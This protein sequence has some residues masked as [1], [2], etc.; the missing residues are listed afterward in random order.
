MRGFLSLTVVVFVFLFRYFCVLAFPPQS[1]PGEHQS[2]SHLTLNI[3]GIYLSTHK[4]LL[5]HN[6][7]NST[8]RTPSEALNEFF[9]KDRDSQ[10]HFLENVYAITNYQ[11]EVQR[12]LADKAYYHVNGEQI[13][14]AHNHVRSLR[15]SLID[16]SKSASTADIEILRERTG[17]CLYTIQQFYSNTNWVELNDDTI[18]KEFGIK[19][20]LPEAVN[21]LSEDTCYDCPTDLESIQ[22]GMCMNNTITT[23]LTSGY[24]AGQDVAKPLKT[25][26]KTGK[27]SHG[28]QDD[29]TRL[30]TATG[31]IYKGRSS[32]AHAPHYHLHEQAFEAAKQASVYFLS[33]EDDGLFNKLGIHLS[34]EIFQIKSNTGNKE[35]KDYSIAFI[36]DVTGSMSDNI[37]GVKQGTTSFVNAIKASENV[38]EKYIL[39]TFS[40]PVDFETSRVTADADE[41]ID[42]LGSL[43]ASG[44]ADCPEY[45][46][47]GL[48]TGATLSN[49]NSPV[50]IYTDAPAKDPEK[51]AEAIRILLEKNIT[52]KFRL[53]NE[54]GR[55]RKR[56]I[57]RYKRQSSV[58]DRIAQTTGGD[59]QRFSSS[60]ELASKVEEDLLNDLNII[61]SNSSQTLDT[62]NLPSSTSVIK[63][64]T[65]D[66]D[67]TNNLTIEVDD[68][69]DSLHIEINGT[70]NS[71]DIQLRNPNGTLILLESVNG[72]V[73]QT[74]IQISIQT[75]EKGEWTLKKVNNNNQ[76]N[77]TITA[78]S[79]FDITSTLLEMSTEGIPYPVKGNP[80]S[81][82]EYL[83]VTSLQNLPTNYTVSFLTLVD[84]TGQTISKMNASLL[85]ASPSLQYY[86]K[87]TITKQISGIQ[88]HGADFTGRPFL[89]S[90]RHAITPVDVSLR[91]RPFVGDLSL[92]KLEQI[93]YTITNHGTANK[94]VVVTVSD[95]RSY[96]VGNRSLTLVIQ[97]GETTEESFSIRGT[98]PLTIVTVKISVEEKET[99]VE[100]QT[101]T[102]KLT[103]S[104]A[105]RP[106]CKVT[107]DEDTCRS[108]IINSSSC[109]DVVWQGGAEFNF[110]GTLLRSLYVS[111]SS[112]NLTHSSLLVSSGLVDASLR[113]D[114]C[115]SSVVLSAIDAEGFVSQCR[116]ILYSEAPSDNIVMDSINPMMQES[117]LPSSRD[118]TIIGGAVGGA[119]AGIIIVSMAV[120]LKLHISNSKI[121]KVN[122]ISHKFV[123]RSEKIKN[124]HFKNTEKLS[125]P[126]AARD[127]DINF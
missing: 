22:N 31:G 49:H 105:I 4:F 38:P 86:A 83:V 62:D 72:Y 118:L 87:T 23:K 67:D 78:N 110:S 89:R 106:S 54:C 42:W 80:L 15:K 53:T 70:T 20:L 103:V 30:R 75:P 68:S 92:S 29:T 61:Q 19:E 107:L 2:K 35:I 3:Y 28:S 7:V 74:G 124:T 18:L 100:L 8:G 16:L 32:A 79:S 48:I 98:T 73:Q 50:Y 93:Q 123:D 17:H 116:F 59:V 55:R 114:C 40:D 104:S 14:L 5:K 36:V 27:C 1:I 119:I 9:G 102:K 112:V 47:S 13:V 58:Y 65:I 45:S 125:Q 109:G 11:N 63:W 88:F 127:L 99:L 122:D 43:S 34:T 90:V 94:I 26:Q 37:N 71:S 21:D 84:E 115:S 51:E 126:S 57:E 95:D 33:D 111:S 81:G 77:V 120:F 121:Y 44:G 91:M 96:I 82:K 24:K 66:Q 97:P 117:S 85:S 39:V 76:W 64:G 10:T 60:S 69:V 108:Q 25:E 6:L 56:A 101:V 12:E 41:M 46:L 113:G 52:A